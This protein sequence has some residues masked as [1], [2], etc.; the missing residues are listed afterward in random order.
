MTTSARLAA[1]HIPCPL[2]ASHAFFAIVSSFNPGFSICWH[3]PEPNICIC[4][5]DRNGASGSNPRQ[6]RTKKLQHCLAQNSCLPQSSSNRPTPERNNRPVSRFAQPD[7]DRN[8]V[9]LW[10]QTLQRLLERNWE[11]NRREGSAHGS[12]ATHTSRNSCVT[13]LGAFESVALPGLWQWPA[14]CDMLTGA[15]P[16]L[17]SR[18]H[19]SESPLGWNLR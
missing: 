1:A 5:R 10:D 12:R 14:P 9:L 11:R 13:F 4:S 6:Y 2:R 19:A 17:F 16:I 7:A 3:I 8:V 15:P 18:G